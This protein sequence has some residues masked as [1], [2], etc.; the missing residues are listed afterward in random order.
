[1]DLFISFYDRVQDL[2][3]VNPLLATVVGA[4]A[5]GVM[6]WAL[7]NVPTKIF[8][9]L[10]QQLTTSLTINN[11]GYGMNKQQFEAFMQWFI[12]N[13]WSKYSRDL[14]MDGG[15]WDSDQVVMGPGYGTHFFFYNGWFYWFVKRR[16]ESSGTA[17]EKEAIDIYTL[18]R[19]QHR[20]TD[21]INEFKYRPIPTELSVYRLQDKAWH[22]AVAIKKR[23]LH[24]VIVKQAIKAQL[25]SQLDY[26]I[27]NAQWYHH[28]GMAHKLTF[29]LHGKPGTGKT[30]LIKALASHYNRNIYQININQ[31]SDTLFEAAI[32]SVPRGAFILIE[33]FD[34]SGATHRREPLPVIAA[35]SASQPSD[36]PVAP[37]EPAVGTLASAVTPLRPMDEI[38]AVMTSMLSLTAVLNTLDGIVTLDDTVIFMTTNHLEKIDS[39][40]TRKG[41]VDHIV[42]IPRLG[43]TEIREYIEL[44]YPG[45]EV[46]NDRHFATLAG[47]DLQ[48][49]FLEHRDDAAAFIQG[50]PVQ[51]TV[52]VVPREKL[53]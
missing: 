48:A 2:S 37:L 25:L 4:W 30:S 24:T 44:M 5:L 53:G 47:C 26:F 39:A 52:Q 35:P 6:T 1:M 21:L 11:A 49:L 45:T 43:D 7:R 31:M 9:F 19:R 3:K 40:I 22:P 38:T 15:E 32:S 23:P 14:S 46:P 29:I 27:H 34:S 50:L 12:Q 28:R 36:C 33:D 10:K 18:G 51:P 41:R 13:N 20:I 17:T 16:L 8:Q 42:E